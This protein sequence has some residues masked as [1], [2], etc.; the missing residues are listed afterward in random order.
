AR[1]RGRGRGRGGAGAPRAPLPCPTCGRLFRFPYY[2]SRHR[3]SHSGLRPHACPLCP[4][5]FRRPA[6]LSRHLRGHGP[7][8]P[9]RC[10]ACPRTFPEPAQLRRHLAQEHAGGE[11]ELATERAAKEEGEG[12][13]QPAAGAE[14]QPWAEG[15]PTPAAPPSAEPR[16]P[17]PGA[18]EAGAAELRAELALAAGRQEE[19]QVLLQADWTLLCLRCREAFA[20]KG[21]LKAHPCLRPEGEQE[22]EGGPPPR[23]K[24]HQCSI[25]LKAFARPWSLSR[26]RLVHSTD[27]PFVCPDC[28]LAFR[29]ASYLRQHRRVHGPLSLLVPL[30]K[31]DDR[32]SGARNSGRGPEGGEGAA[33]GGGGGGE[34]GG[35]AGPARAPAG[36]PRFWCPECGKG[37]RRRAHLRQHGVTHSGARPFQCVRC[38]REFKRL[39][40]LARHAQVHAGG[41]APHLCPRCPR[42]FSRAYSLLRHQRCHRAELELERVAALQAAQSPLPEQEAEGV[43]LPLARI[44]EEP[45]SPGTPPQSPG[46]PPVFLSASCFDS[47]DHSAFKMEEDEVDS[48]AHLRGLG[49]LA[50]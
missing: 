20:T 15:E 38:Q 42:R 5:A 22:G 28:G 45:P 4:K 46:A 29:L 47:Q 31:K 25:C 36:E 1:G 50:S 26:H 40:D 18:A 43:P 9:L 37:F 35:D 19:K 8:P 14:E 21:E 33:E 27:R 41:P 16:T 10:A 12:A 6:H 7:Q 17:E 11:V 48:K 24:R 30:P 32:A 23:P 3:L 2:L 34:N 39:A 13:P 44:K 49:G